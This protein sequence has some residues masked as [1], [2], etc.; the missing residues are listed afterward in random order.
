M[1]NWQKF[2]R[3]LIVGVSNTLLCLSIMSL[4]AYWGMNYIAYTALGYLITIL[5]SF[6]MNLRFTFR[7]QGQIAKRLCLFFAV[8]VG[9][10]L[11]VEVIEYILIDLFEI[12]TVIAILCGMSWYTVTGFLINHLWV[13]RASKLK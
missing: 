6:F 3:Y 10:L 7:A 8:S 5:L 13:Y 9:N 11:L 2:F 12:K 1:N 4:G